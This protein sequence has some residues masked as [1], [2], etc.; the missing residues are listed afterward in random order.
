MMAEG[1][2]LGSDPMGEPIKLANNVVGGCGGPTVS[3][4]PAPTC[5]GTESRLT[6]DITTDNYPG[7]TTWTL[8]NSC[9]SSEVLSGGPYTS[10]DTLYSQ[11]TPQCLPDDAKYVFTINDS[12][13]DGICCSYGSGGYVV[14]QDDAQ[15]LSGG[16][17]G[18]SEVA[19]FG[20]CG[21]SPTTSP[22]V[23]S[24]PPTAQPTTSPPTKNPTPAPINSQTA[25]PTYFTCSMFNESAC[26]NAYGG[27][28]CQ[29][30][31]TCKNCGCVPVLPSASR[32]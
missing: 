16:E 24:P 4:T 28:K 18:S 21:S 29:W 25:S 5:S 31:G 8:V 27:N 23:S 12:Y 11:T 19:S 26:A 32:N 3:P 20:S 7:E 22:P 2:L 17:F 9:D 15:A 1:E 14:K 30:V 13:G 10:A 6:V